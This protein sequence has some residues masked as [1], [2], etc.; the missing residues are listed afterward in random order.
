MPRCTEAR[1]GVELTEALS[2]NVVSLE[3]QEDKSAQCKAG[4]SSARDDDLRCQSI[5]GNLPLPSNNLCW[6]SEREGRSLLDASRSL[7][8]HGERH[9]YPSDFVLQ[10]WLLCANA[11]DWRLWD[12]MIDLRSMTGC[13]LLPNQAIFQETSRSI[14]REL[15]SAASTYKLLLQLLIT[16]KPHLPPLLWGDR[17]G[18]IPGRK[19]TRAVRHSPMI[20]WWSDRHWRH[21]HKSRFYLDFARH[22]LLT[23]PLEVYAFPFRAFRILIQCGRVL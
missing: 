3:G 12:K 14:E 17:H 11:M 18:H 16:A 2:C 19:L 15:A 8:L 21:L 13:S 23:I 4:C 22:L 6:A 9:L 5:R 20:H 7:N 10:S 1:L